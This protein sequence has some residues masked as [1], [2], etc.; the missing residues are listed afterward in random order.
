MS[1]KR[2]VKIKS[3]ADRRRD[4]ERSLE[5]N[6]MLLLMRKYPDKA[7]EAVKKLT[8]QTV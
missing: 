5:V 3:E 6:Y 2:E 4:S 7:K 8:P 1:D